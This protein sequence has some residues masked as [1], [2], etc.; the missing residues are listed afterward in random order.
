MN[1]PALLLGSTG[2]LIALF[3]PFILGAFF[4]LFFIPAFLRDGS[5]PL[6]IGHAVYLYFMQALGVILMS[7]GGIP[8]VYGVFAD[9][10]YSVNTYLALLIIFAAGGI[11]FLFHYAHATQLSA[12]ARA[13]PEALY[14][15]TIKSLGF[16]VMIFAGLNLVVSMLLRATPFVR[17]WWVMPMTLFL[18][19]ILLLWLT[20]EHPG[21][22]GFMH[23]AVASK[24]KK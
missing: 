1:P 22:G 20:R 8:I 24:K 11:T 19:G 2:I 18:Y 14:F 10:A 7:L 15:Y 21:R 4:A 3:L 5:T 16:I 23:T 6:A 13:V 9:E 17:G 12:A